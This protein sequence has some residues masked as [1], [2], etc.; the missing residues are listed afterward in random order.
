[1]KITVEEK[2][3]GYFGDFGGRYVPETL[4][5][6]LEELE[7]VYNASKEDPAIKAEVGALL[8]DYAGRPTPL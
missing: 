6:A 4:I 8:S 2:R 3:K 7:T 5:P 1:M